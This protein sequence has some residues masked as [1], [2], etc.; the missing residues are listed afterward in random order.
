MRFKIAHHKK[1][2]PYGSAFLAEKTRTPPRIFLWWCFCRCELMKGSLR[3]GAPDWVGWGRARWNKTYIN[4]KSRGLLPPLRDPP[5]SRRKALA[6]RFSA[7]GGFG[8]LP[9]GAW[10]ATRYACPRRKR[11]ESRNKSNGFYTYAIFF[12]LWVNTMFPNNTFT[13]TVFVL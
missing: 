5:S 12:Q 2:R 4:L 7:D 11:R 9:D 6:R 8:L 13:E 10:T 3:E 1:E